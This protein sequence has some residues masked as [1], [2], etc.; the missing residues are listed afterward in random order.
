MGPNGASK[1]SGGSPAKRAAGAD[2]EAFRRRRAA[3]G[4]QRDLAQPGGDRRG[5]VG[6]VRDE[7]RAADRRRVEVARLQVEMLGHRQHADRSDAGR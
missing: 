1:W 2:G 6:D 7:R 3:V 5:G 4:D